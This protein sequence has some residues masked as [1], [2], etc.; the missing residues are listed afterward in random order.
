V[1]RVVLVVLVVVSVLVIVLVVAALVL[2][3]MVVVVS[4]LVVVPVQLL[5]LCGDIAVQL[6]LRAHGLPPRSRRSRWPSWPVLSPPWDAAAAPWSP[7]HRFFR[8]GRA[9]AADP[10]ENFSK[11]PLNIGL[12]GCPFG[13]PRVYRRTRGRRKEA[14]MDNSEHTESRTMPMIEPWTIEGLR[15]QDPRSFER[16]ALVTRNI[17]VN[18]FRRRRIIDNPID[19]ANSLARA[20]DEIADYLVDNDWQVTPEE[21][22]DFIR[23]ALDKHTKRAEREARRRVHGSAHVFRNRHTPL[24]DVETMKKSSL[25]FFFVLLDEAWQQLAAKRP[26]RHAD[27]RAVLVRMRR[28]DDPADLELT[29]ADRFAIHSLRRALIDRCLH[30]AKKLG[31]TDDDDLRGLVDTLR[32][33]VHRPKDFLGAIDKISDD[34]GLPEDRETV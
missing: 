19:R 5:R 20:S 33:G 1:V 12:L 27:A 15:N 7:A 34:D 24:P 29:R 22:T 4:V 21:L 17:A 14:S 10:R 16:L 11:I 13:V 31:A 26:V 25:R 30:H 3:P 28:V 32:R 18:L 23:R 9:T 6:L 2:V 8:I